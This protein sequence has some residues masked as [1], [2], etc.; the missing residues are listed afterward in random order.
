MS[1]LLNTA[2][3]LDRY[4]IFSS[5]RALRSHAMRGEIPYYRL[6]HGHFYF[7]RTDIEH[8][9]RNF[10]HEG[11]PVAPLSTLQGRLPVTAVVKNIQRYQ[12]QNL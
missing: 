5:Q 12:A 2:E 3:V 4:P 6:N 8:F 10:R 1:E 9:L 7:C 11:K